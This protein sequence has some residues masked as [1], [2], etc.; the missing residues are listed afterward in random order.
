MVISVDA[1]GGGKIGLALVVIMAA[2]IA[3]GARQ[4]RLDLA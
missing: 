4:G 2:V 3:A 1:G